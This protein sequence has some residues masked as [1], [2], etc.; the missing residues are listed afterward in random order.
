[1]SISGH[2]RAAVIKRDDATCYLCHRRLELDEITIDH[3]T[4]PSRGGNDAIENLKVA[5]STCN[6]IK[7]SR[8]V[9]ECDASEFI[10][11]EPPLKVNGA[12]ARKREKFMRANQRLYLARIVVNNNTPQAVIE[13]MIAAVKEQ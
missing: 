6:S 8:L 11:D 4:P 3:V 9:S 12:G 1:V 7:G 13:R 2:K 10:P 5:C